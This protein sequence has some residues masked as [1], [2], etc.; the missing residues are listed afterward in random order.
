MTHLTET[1]FVDLLDGRLDAG[2]LRHVQACETC[3]EQARALGAVVR[4]VQADPMPE[5][6]PL[7][8]ERLSA[9]VSETIQAGP[10][11]SR[12]TGLVASG[13]WR[14]AAAAAVLLL[15]TGVS[16]QVFVS[17]DTA[18]E[19]GPVAPVEQTLTDSSVEPDGEAFVDAWD[20]IEAVADLEWDEAQSI[21]IASGPG[22]A[23]RHVGDLTDAERGELVRLI[24][25]AM[26]R[27]GA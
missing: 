18:S 9:R 7:F 4:S 14:L 11:P 21:G 22:S 23:E 15:V 5:P 1:E 6:S 27:H 8:W 3:R 26:K 17:R 10:P 25:E 12:W 16:W 20:A 2:R 24:E 19:L 13:R